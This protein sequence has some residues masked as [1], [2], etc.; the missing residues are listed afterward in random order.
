MDVTLKDPLVGLVLD[1]RYRVQSRIARGGMAT[2]YL[3][4]DDRLDREVALKVMHGHLS[5]D[6]EFVA[7]FIREA[8]SAA[9][10]SHPNVIQVFDQG[11]DRGVLYLAMEH[12][13]GRTLREVL[14]ERGALTPREALSVME[15]VLDALGAA[16]RAGIVHRDMKPENVL[17]TDDGRIKVAD[18]GLARAATTT[19]TT[20]TLIGTVAYLAPELVAR[21]IA[22]ARS[23]VYACG[24]LLFEMLTGRQPFTGDLPIQVAFQHVHEHVPAPSELV[25]ELPEEL[26]DVVLS[27]TAQDPDDRPANAADMLRA[28]RAAKADLD[29]EVL[30]HRPFVAPAD[31]EDAR[32]DT[33]VVERDSVLRATQAIPGGYGRPDDE[34]DDG[35]TEQGEL[36]GDFD[37]G[38]FDDGEF[39]GDFA[40]EDVDEQFDADESDEPDEA[41]AAPRRGRRLLTML[42]VAA[43]VIAGGAWWWLAGPGTYMT[44]PSVDGMPVADA[45]KVVEAADLSTT[46]EQVFDDAVEV[47]HVVRTTPEGGERVKKDGS[48]VLAVSKG[49]Q[50]FDVPQV[51]GQPQDDARTALT[52]AELSPTFSTAYSD[53][54]VTGRVISTDPKAGERLRRGSAVLVVVS[55]GP[56]PVTVPNLVEKTQE[57]A[58]K[59]LTTLK[60]KATVT[61]EISE[62][63]EKGKVISQNPASGTLLPGQSVALV[64]SS[65]PPLVTVPNVF[66]MSYAQAREVLERAGFKTRRQG[67]RI[68]DQVFE[69]RPRWG[70]KAPKGSTIIV[71][72]F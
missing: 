18:F 50:L 40:G 49:P 14:D 59:A 42:L 39:D 52:A 64:V 45:V 63:V 35:E 44:T 26:D 19:A 65:G 22:D 3:A 51:V 21:G 57:E 27:A 38:E 66:R 12:L 9:R 1:G 71:R 6:D 4:L 48:V 67:S 25:P 61:T 8:R 24:I 69:T 68:F 43:L 7:R 62:K 15:P 33:E 60:L 30:D 31:T 32:T 2:V 56:Q 72:T 55:Q 28:L 29:P 41:A 53:T 17:L 5:E 37:D 13:P 20:G 36:D 10:L 34:F 23:D 11:S 54:V 46:Q 47:G 16:H 70:S 58:E